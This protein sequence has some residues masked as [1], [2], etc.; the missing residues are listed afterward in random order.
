MIA[1]FLAITAFAF[2][3]T[4]DNES[5]E[6]DGGTVG[7]AGDYNTGDIAVINAIIDNNKLGWTKS[8]ADGSSVHSTWTGAEWSMAATDKRITHLNLWNKKLTG[9]L[10][11]SGLTALE[12]LDCI[13]NNLTSLDV[14]NNTA[15]TVL[16]CGYNSL[17]SLDLSNNTALTVLYCRFNNLTSLDL[18]GLTALTHLDCGYNSLTS[19]D[20]S[21]NTALTDLLCGWNNLTSLNVSGCT[22][23]DY[24]YCHQNALTELD[25]TG[26]PL[27]SI[28]ICYEN[29]MPSD[30][31][32]VTGF[33]GTWNGSKFAFDP[34][35]TGTPLKFIF[36]ESFIILPSDGKIPIENLNVSSG[37][38]GGNGTYNFS[39]A[40]FPSGLTLD[41]TTGVIS[42]TLG[43]EEYGVMTVYVS[44]DNGAM[45]VI[46]ISYSVTVPS[47]DDGDGNTLLIV[48]VIA[49]VA[50]AAL[51][52]Y[53]FLLRPRSKA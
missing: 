27:K 22:E 53:W 13:Y 25:L 20:V 16:Y 28:L 21:N 24:L 36:N 48:A 32:T 26:C 40:D 35:F 2:F 37:V 7:A 47:D 10:D 41:S 39:Y 44:D 42:G 50:V 31:S 51:A 34:Q 15:L 6:Y 9:A 18:S 12:T 43:E 23:L 49:I 29:Y 38:S 5:D 19:L 45:R 4:A 1:A 17:T 30:K 52:T 33:N 14:S 3:L 8:P 46:R 11:V